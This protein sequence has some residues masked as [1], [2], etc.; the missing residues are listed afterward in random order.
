ME[1]N[2][3]LVDFWG[4]KRSNSSKIWDFYGFYKEDGVVN[5]AEAVCKICSVK[6][7]YTG[8]TSNLLYHLNNCHPDKVFGNSK[9]DSK[10]KQSKQPSL[11]D[12]R[13][14]KPYSF[15]S[16]QAK[17]LHKK[18]AEFIVEEML[19]LSTVEKESFRDLVEAL[20]PQYRVLSRTSLKDKVIPEMY[21]ETRQK[22][23]KNLNEITGAAV[24][25]DG[26]TSI[27]TKGYVTVTVHYIDNEWNLR[28]A[29]LETKELP[30]SHTAEHLKDAMLTTLST[31]N[32]ASIKITGIFLVFSH[33]LSHKPWQH[34]FQLTSF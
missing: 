22:L 29:V 8:S 26:W 14:K 5:K 18:V 16:S 21:E 4:Q 30:G 17:K 32:L 31:W 24:T 6:L 23:L 20:D 13:S 28:S 33:G 3:V 15:E 25:T 11:F 10:E 1:G 34:I 2:K 19:P 27:A 9:T 12:F 7:K